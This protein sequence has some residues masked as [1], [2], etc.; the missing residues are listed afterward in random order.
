MDNDQLL[1]KIKEKAEYWKKKLIDLSKRNNLVNYRF[2]KTKSLKV[3]QP[4]FDRIVEDLNDEK[5]LK[6]LKEE[7]LEI[8]KKY[9]FCNEEEDVVDKK[10]T[11]LYLKTKDNF[12]ELGISTCFVSLGM[13]EYVGKDDSNDR[14][15]APIFL[16][17]ISLSRSPIS[18][19]KHKFELIPGSE[20]V[21]VNP[22]L[23]EKLSVEFNISLPK[24]DKEKTIQEY[25]DSVKKAVSGM[26]EWD[27]VQEV[28]I[29]VF[30]Y[31]KYVMFND[32]IKHHEFLENSDLIKALVGDA[33]MLEDEMADVVNRNYDDSEGVEVL[34][35]DS[36]QKFA[37]ELAKSGTTFVLEGPPGT[38]KS[39]TIS[40][41]IASLLEQKKKVLFVSQKMAALDVVYKRLDKIGLGRYC[42]NLHNYKGNKKEIVRQLASEL[43]TAP[44]IKETYKNYSFAD[45]VE[46]QR[47]LNDFYQFLCKKREPRALSIYNIRGELSKLHSV[48]V[49][50][51]SLSEAVSYDEGKFT[52]LLSKI[53]SLDSSLDKIPRPLEDIY[54]DFNRSRNTTLAREKLKKLVNVTHEALKEILELVKDIKTNLNLEISTVKELEDF[55]EFHKMAKKLEDI[56]SFLVSDNFPDYKKTISGLSRNLNEMNGCKSKILEKAKEDFIEK[57]T[58]AHEETFRK[59]SFF[60]RPF[61][62]KYRSVKNELKNSSKQK[63]SHNDWIELFELKNQYRKFLD[64]HNEIESK[65]QKYVSYL[66]DIKSIGNL[67][68]L[69]KKAEEISPSFENAKM[70]TEEPAKL[71]NYWLNEY[72]KEE[73]LQDLKEKTEE[74]DSY[75]KNSPLRKTKNITEMEKFVHESIENLHHLDDIL[76]FK[77]TYESLN[78]E[79]KEFIK[80]YFE[81]DV[82]SKLSSTFL[83]SYYLQLLEEILKQENILSPKD[84]IRKFREKDSEVR[85]VKRFKIMDSIE[86]DQPSLNYQSYGNSEVSILKREN[87][88]KKRLKP[89]RDLLEQ[90]PNLAFSLKPCFMMSPLSVSQYI[91]PSSVKFDVVI[92]DE[93]SQIMPEDAITC[94]IRAKQAI[95]VGDTQQLPPT[96]F[97]MSEKE[98]GGVEEEI[99]DLE[100][101]LS[102]CST[103]LRTECLAWHYRSENEHLIAFSNRFFY[104]NR[105]ITFP[106]SG[107]KG[108]SAL[109]FIHVKNG[110][111]DRGKSRKNRI[112][113][114][115]VVKKYKELKK[116]FPDKSIGIIA[117]GISQKEAIREEFENQRLKIEESIE[118]HAEDLFIKNIETVQGDERDITII[119]VGYGKNS[120]GKLS[121]H[122][123]PLNKDGGSK[124]L[125]V[126]IT[127]SRFKTVVVSSIAPEDLDEEKINIDGVRHLKHYLDYAKNKNFDKFLKTGEGQ[128]F[129]SSFEESVYDAL[130][131]E[132]FS[133]STQIGCSGY[134]IDLAIKHPENPGNYVLGVECDGAQY[135]S[136]I[137]S[138]DR[139]KVRQ[140]ILER[141]G[142]NIH[143]IWSEDWLNDREDEIR[144]IKEKVSSLL[145]ST[146]EKPKKEPK[147]EKVENVENFREISLKDKYKE[148]E[149]AVMPRVRQDRYDANWVYTRRAQELIFLVLEA[150]SPIEKELLYKRVLSSFGIKRLG[151][152]IKRG[153]D[154]RINSLEGKNHVYVSGETISLDKI[155]GVC[156]IRIS[157][158]SERPFT[159]IP[160]EEI[161]GA[162]IDILK[163]NF[164]TTKETLVADIAKGIFR[165]NRTGGKIKN[166]IEESIKYLLNKKLIEEKDNKFYFRK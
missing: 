119:S 53:Q 54:F 26:K 34:P 89:I 65:N 56:P 40:N 129:D 60:T 94:L 90:I 124:R 33:S 93:A 95:I 144:K 143:R 100:S 35:A 2:T 27:V 38:G 136:S 77:Q 69:K 99:E 82:V 28:Y 3:K 133:M 52:K 159:L 75:W 7:S 25:I 21:Q 116:E 150:E 74:L 127:R 107:V 70:L 48:E 105:L 17:P 88:K 68:H 79:M 47:D 16:Y 121:Y 15:K 10:L 59:T 149:I 158:E 103:K 135:H 51:E 36:S 64:R 147:L 44:Y 57:E 151:V 140:S 154:H 83:K 39:Q 61:S 67:G 41:M 91:N 108:E 166:K 155:D 110:V 101:F 9:W 98:D 131:N 120:S 23:I 6:I 137:F 42:L 71:L 123:G 20:D 8:K 122:F 63:L 80:K 132:G 85:N 164:G 165:N 106:N 19:D 104:E 45:Y 50:H 152:N 32:L 11:N 148:Y 113:A 115:E 157:K 160:K 24:F 31:Q 55:C 117:F 58:L 126:A 162:I 5:N 139:D 118:S 30:S 146:G 112:E 96:S 109:E 13:L 1:R 46:T 86:R 125:N 72:P 92:F 49:F 37:I 128:C 114:R 130:T 145:K 97:F 84:K 22:A 156:P 87:E 14:L 153:F 73:R 29:D 66:G 76:V 111:Y 163:N 102:E 43:E 12:Q 4:D 81:E 161:G 134:R 142:W 18:K 141:L 138:R 78:K 62:K